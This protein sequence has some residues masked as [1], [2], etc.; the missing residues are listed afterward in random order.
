M[1]GKKSRIASLLHWLGRAGWWRRFSFY[2][3]LGVI[4]ATVMTA[5]YPPPAPPPAA[6][7]A[8]QAVELPGATSTAGSPLDEPIRLVTQAQQSYRDVRDYTCRLIKHE[9][10]D[11]KL[12]PQNTMQ[13]CVRSAPFSVYFKWLEPSGLAGQEVCYV[14][15][16]NNDK[17]RVR[18]RGLLGAVGFVTL[19]V[20]DPRARATSAHPITEAGIGNLIEQFAAGW[21]RER[22]W[23]MTEVHL[24]E[25]VFD[26]RRCIR[27]ETTHPTNPDNRFLH[28]RDVVFFDKETHL[29]VRMEAYGWP[30]HPGDTGDL[31]EMYSYAGLR[32]NVGLGEAMFNK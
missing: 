12:Q 3:L 23:N 7:D 19:D 28:F 18:P 14:A 4:G 10:V 30:R 13:M 5:A 11:G 15:G 22:R 21:E 1:L 32:S 2:G 25:Y 27:V 24:G 31:L 8:P 17:L 16:R 20:N 6:P 29:P 26:H 9:R